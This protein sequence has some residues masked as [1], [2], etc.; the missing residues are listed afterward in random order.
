MTVGTITVRE[1]GI[2]VIKKDASDQ[3]AYGY[4]VTSSPTVVNVAATTFT[5]AAAGDYAILGMGMFQ[6]S[7]TTDNFN[8]KLL[9]DGVSYSQNAFRSNHVNNVYPWQ[10]LVKVNL[11]ADSHT[12]AIQE[13]V[14]SAGTIT[15]EAHLLVMDW[16]KFQHAYYGE[17]RA[18]S[19]TTSTTYQDKVT[20]TQV[21]QDGPYDHVVIGVGATDG[22]P[23]ETVHNITIQDAAT[24][25]ENQRKYPTGVTQNQ[26]F[27]SLAKPAPAAVSTTWKTQYRSGGGLS[28]GIQDSAI[29]ILQTGG[30]SVEIKGA[31]ILG[32]NIL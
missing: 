29:M 24:I 10:G 28:V 22:T 16:T 4:V 5:L 25:Q 30:A 32:A 11:D 23:K 13:W 14:D 18:P 27:F 21:P 20:L 19:T 3:H 9:V 7:N 26:P 31:N 8:V 15:G 2:L 12:I 17:S 1:A 6:K